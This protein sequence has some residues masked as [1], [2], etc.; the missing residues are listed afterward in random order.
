MARQAGFHH[1]CGTTVR[2][3]SPTCRFAHSFLLSSG[4][5]QAQSRNSIIPNAPKDLP[6]SS[7]GSSTDR[8]WEKLA[9]SEP[10]PASMETI[11][12]DM[13]RRTSSLR[14]GRFRRDEQVCRRVTRR[15]ARR[16]WNPALLAA[17]AGSRRRRSGDG[18]QGGQR[19]CAVRPP[20]HHAR[21]SA[22]EWVLHLQQRG[23]RHASCPKACTSWNGCC[24]ST[25]TYTTATAPKTPST[26][27]GR[28]CSSH[29]AAAALSRHGLGRRQGE[30]PAQGLV[31]N[32]PCRAGRAT[33]S[34]ERLY[35]EAGPS[36]AVRSS[37]R[38]FWCPPG[39]D[40][41]KDDLLGSLGL[42]EKGFAVMTQIVKSL[43]ESVA[44]AG[45]C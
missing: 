22:A 13:T 8:L 41:H 39:Y 28:V 37:R 11:A 4:L 44:E 24:L 40:S 42:D 29:A 35:Q 2:G 9:H 12:G 45:W 15:C 33:R 1:G 26:R 36:R 21:P 17:G 5:P 31:M 14:G 7:S 20:G 16:S 27:D 6:G 10:K 23:H 19:F 18:R 38:S 34:S 30:G 3:E 25:G 43:A 32:N